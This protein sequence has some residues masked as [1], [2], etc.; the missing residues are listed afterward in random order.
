M[1]LAALIVCL[2]FVSL[3]AKASNLSS[4]IFNY[5]GF[6]PIKDD[7]TGEISN[8]TLAVDESSGGNSSTSAMEEAEAAC[9]RLIREQSGRF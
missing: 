3:A 9:W 5:Q 6:M 8:E 4:K 2:A 1:K 7:R